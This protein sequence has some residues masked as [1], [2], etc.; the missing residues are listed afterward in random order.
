MA[1]RRMFAKTI[2]LSDAFLDMPATTR[3]LYFTLAMLADDDGF[4]NSPKSIMRQSGASEDDLRLLFAKRYILGFDSGVIVIKH[5]KIHNYIQRD[6]YKA[7]S[8]REL[9][10]SVYLDEN[11][12][13]SL[14]PGEGKRP[15]LPP[16]DTDCIQDVSDME[17][18][19]RLDKIRLDKS[20]EDK[21]ST[22]FAPPSH[23]DV[24]TYIA[25][26]GYRMD[27][28]AFIDFYT[29]KD[30]MIGKNKMK[31]WKAAV[32]NWHRRDSQERK[33]KKVKTAPSEEHNYDMDDLRR[34]AKE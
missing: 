21:K 18:Q 5:W 24:A 27:A 10:R 9:L 8:F 30:W 29:S 11:K 1:E 33:S 17:T 7:S 28:D 26:K 13:Y 32:R 4:V 22:R 20:R 3:C 25:E 19:N 12:A 2:V 16:L 6:R 23:E 31:D 34:R 14:T 15:A